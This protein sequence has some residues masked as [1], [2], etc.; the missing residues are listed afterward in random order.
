MSLKLEDWVKAKSVRVFFEN[1]DEV[2]FSFSGKSWADINP[3]DE[4]TRRV[5]VDGHKIIYDPNSLVL[6]L[7]DKLREERL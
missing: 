7:S 5:M 1:G 2:E 4:G 3:I 6:K